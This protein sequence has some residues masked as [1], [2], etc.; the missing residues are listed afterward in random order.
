[1]GESRFALFAVAHHVDASV[2]LLAHHLSHGG[3]YPRGKG[4]VVVGLAG[5]L[6]PHHRQQIGWPGQTPGMRGQDTIGTALHG[7]ISL[8]NTRA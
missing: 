4:R 6:G 2:H 7:R 3:A 1:M 8:L 5:L